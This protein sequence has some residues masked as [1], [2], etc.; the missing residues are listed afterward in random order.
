VF[1]NAPLLILDD[2]EHSVAE[3]R[4]PEDLLNELKTLANKKDVPYQS[5][6]KSLFAKQI[7]VE[8]ESLSRGRG[9]D[10]LKKPGIQMT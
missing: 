2:P 9:A 7:A 6:A 8:R 5:L 4:L 1:C 10:K 3:I